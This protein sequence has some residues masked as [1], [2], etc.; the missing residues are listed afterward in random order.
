M[1]ISVGDFV[2]L[3]N[4]WTKMVIIDINNFGV[5]IAKYTHRSEPT[6]SDFKH[7]MSV[8]GTKRR[9]L[10]EFVLWKEKEN[11]MKKRYRVKGIT[12]FKGEVAQ[13]IGMTSKGDI[14]VEFSGLSGF[15]CFHPSELEEVIPYTFSV[16]SLVGN[17]RC[18]YEFERPCFS[19][20]DVIQSNSGNIYVVTGVDTRSGRPKKVFE[21]YKLKK[22]KI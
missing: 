5:A 11:I 20:G 19:T 6:A 13:E 12:A 1:N 21:G 15:G 4:G 7:P 2:R 18:H 17:H 22:E 16:K 14:V 10:S 3:R 8:P 9:R